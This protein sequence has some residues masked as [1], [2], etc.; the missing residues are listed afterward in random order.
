MLGTTGVGSK[1]VTGAL[2]LLCCEDPA[3]KISEA[4]QA[5]QKLRV[6]DLQVHLPAHNVGQEVAQ[7]L[8]Q[9]KSLRS[10][11][12]T[13][14]AD[15]NTISETL[16]ILQQMTQLEHLKLAMQ[17]PLATADL[18]TSEFLGNIM[19][20]PVHVRLLTL[21]IEGI[22][23]MEDTPGALT[24]CELEKQ[25]GEALSER[26]GDKSQISSCVAEKYVRFY[27]KS[28]G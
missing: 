17:A 24:I 19:Q 20:L 1:I 23:G 13:T 7:E 5:L 25:T 26:F 27:V 9:W 11:A 3:E 16:Q 4:C 28:S 8:I 12:L 21:E 14:F 22:E 15:A 18:N 10:L 2:D 6:L